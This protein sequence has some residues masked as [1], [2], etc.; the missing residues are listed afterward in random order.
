MTSYIY[1]CFPQSFC[2]SKPKTMMM[3]KMKGLMII[4]MVE[5]TQ[6]FP[7]TFG[8]LQ[9][10]ICHIER[11]KEWT[12]SPELLE[13]PKQEGGERGGGG[14]LIWMGGPQTPLHT[15]YW[16]H[17]PGPLK[18]INFYPKTYTQKNVFKI[19]LTPAWKNRSFIRRKQF[20]HLPQKIIFQTTNFI[21]LFAKLVS[22]TCTKEYK[23][24]VSDVF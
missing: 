14:D 18:Q 6:M 12:W 7:L 20:L 13:W 4:C 24:F 11:L 2:F 1:I 5:Q 9:G 8:L 3:M 17:S 15:M 23:S 22:N 16:G 21:Y 10:I 19:F